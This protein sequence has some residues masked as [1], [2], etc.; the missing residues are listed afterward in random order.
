MGLSGQG[1]RRVHL[2]Q[3]TLLLGV[4]YDV[5]AQQLK[6]AR[7]VRDLVLKLT[8]H[9]RLH[10]YFFDLGPDLFFPVD[11]FLEQGLPQVAQG[12]FRARAARLY[13]GANPPIVAGI[14]DLFFPFLIHGG[15]IS[16]KGMFLD[17]VVGQVDEFV[18]AHGGV[19][20]ELDGQWRTSRTLP[21]R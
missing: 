2:D 21:C 18:G 10:N 11:V 12:E 7:V 8:C 20:G 5:V 13:R 19:E 1:G 17:G 3:P 15:R 6:G 14:E 4:Y 16:L 9:Q